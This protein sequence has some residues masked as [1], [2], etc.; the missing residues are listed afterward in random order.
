MV[1]RCFISIDIDNPQILSKFIKIQRLLEESGADLKTVETENMHLTLMFL[2]DVESRLGELTNKIAEMTFKPFKI[3]FK[4][5]GVFPSLSKPRVIWLG[6][7][8]GLE[9]LK[10]IYRDLEQ[11][12]SPIGFKYDDRGFSPHATLAR[13]RSGRNKDKLV[14]ILRNFEDEFLGEMTVKHI[15][16]KKSVLTSRGPI[17]STIIESKSLG[18]P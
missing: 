12:I 8:N 11:R 6:V 14:K 10:L 3:E 13:V 9:E 17:Y 7:S 5:V 1:V 16:L 15:Q 18:E 4:G 2:G